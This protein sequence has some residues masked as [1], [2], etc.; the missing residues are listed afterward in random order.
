MAY[1]LR[2]ELSMRYI[3]IYTVK[4][5]KSMN[6]EDCGVIHLP[7]D[8]GVTNRSRLVRWRLNQRALCGVFTL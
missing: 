3:K 4:S 5:V 7:E 8:R 2:E 6:D 1:K